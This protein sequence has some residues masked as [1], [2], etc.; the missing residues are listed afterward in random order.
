MKSY[1]Y[2]YPQIYSF[3]NLYLAFR[4]ARRGKRKK[5]SVAAFELDLEANLWQLYEELRD[6]TYRPGHYHNFYV[7]ERKRRLISAAPFR[8]RVVHHALCRVIEPIFER[9][10]IYDSY[11]CRL[12]KGTHRAVDRAQEFARRRRYVLQCDLEQFFPSM[13]HQVLLSI[14]RVS[15]PPHASWRSL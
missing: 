11:A 1:K 10:F 6:Q 13:D 7:Q 3:E 14:F 4:K 9:R 8:D 5:E 2:L 12:G 15:N